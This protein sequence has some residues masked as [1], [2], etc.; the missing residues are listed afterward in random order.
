[1]HS[2][3]PNHPLA[4]ALISLALSATT[5]LA[6]I[7]VNAATDF[8]SDV[9]STLAKHDADKDGELTRTELGDAAWMLFA[10]DTNRDGK[11]SKQELRD[12]MG[13]FSTQ[14]F[15]SRKAAPSTSLAPPFEAPVEIQRGPRPLKPADHG[16]DTL[17]RDTG[18]STLE[19]KPVQL[20]TFAGKI[21]TVIAVLDPSCPISQRYF[22]VLA[23]LEKAYRDRGIGFVHV[24]APGADDS[25]ALRATGV[26]G[27]ITRDPEAKLLSALRATHSTDVF[28]LDAAHT[29]IY[30][31]AIDDQ[32]GQGYNRDAAAE[33]YL[34]RALDAM[35]TGQRPR[36]AATQAPGC[37]LELPPV[38]G[39]AAQKVTW[40]NRISRIF[41][42]H[43]GA[44]HREG[45]VGPFPLE[46]PAQV[47]R[48][49]KTIQRVVSDGVMPPWFAPAPP[50]GT[51]SPW[52][53]DRLLP[54]TDRADLLAW[55]SGDRAEG[56][57]KDAPLP[58]AWPQEWRIGQPDTI[59]QIP[60]PIAIPAEGTLPYQSIMVPT[61]FAETRYV[62]AW[63]VRPTA[64][65]LVHHVLV[66][67][68]APG[69]LSIPGA[70]ERRGYLA[71]YVP[72]FDCAIYPDGMAKE[73][74]A[75]STLRFEIHYT[76]NGKPAEDQLRLG[77]KFAPK[78]PPNIV[79]VA[80]IANVHLKIPPGAASHPEAAQWKAPSDI[81]LLSLLPHMHVRGKAARFEVI[82]S[83]NEPRTLLDVPR[84]DFNW[85][86]PTQYAE[87]P[88][89]P[90]GSLLK[91]TGWFDNSSQNPAN[92]NPAATVRWGSQTTDEMM[93]G[94]V[95]Y[96]RGK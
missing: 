82:V 44:C 19:G 14:L 68:Y 34:V 71:A 87:P 21:G 50:P 54:A 79:E 64:P 80:S 95:E 58:R 90:A 53:N 9:E 57:S 59:L 15:P 8:L 20:R 60:K 23:R 26:A 93:I 74:P 56:D 69:I 33:P 46:T 85:Q 78:C 76:P 51:H 4:A 38:S 41:Q 22:P 25:A 12:G 73:I 65:Q 63:E 77:L 66:Y 61:N 72:G 24:A 55:L 32:Y 11:L 96:Y 39:P 49:A 1:V 48:K 37:E 17:I 45:G 31:G 67:V 35:V 3:K 42:A 47:A 5:G 28:L 52:V 89:I 40:H 29:L 18:V 86:I 7:S 84:Y 62:T 16:I 91:V 75:G 30:R 10:I 2:I 92:P 27:P 83:G 6:E 36:V 13:K 81:R 43:C 70:D 88:R 94:Y